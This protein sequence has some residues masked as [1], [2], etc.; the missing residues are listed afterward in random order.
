MTTE[1]RLINI[2]AYRDKDN[3]PCCA[4][5]FRA[6][7]ICPFLRTRNFGT[8]DVCALSAGN[9]LARREEGKG[10]LIPDRECCIVWKGELS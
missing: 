6:G 10:T 3:L 4:A 1:I 9:P 5:D 2:E 7:K 8:Q